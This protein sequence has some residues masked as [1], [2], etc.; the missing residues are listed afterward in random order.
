M[1][2]SNSSISIR[3]ELKES[4]GTLNILKVKQFPQI[5]NA[6]RY[7]EHLYQAAEDNACGQSLSMEY[8]HWYQY[9]HF[10]MHELP[11][12]REYQKKKEAVEKVLRPMTCDAMN[13]LEDVAR[14]MDLQQDE[15]NRLA[16]YSDF[17]DEFDCPPQSTPL[18]P[19]ASPLPDDISA[20]V[21]SST[22][23]AE[24]LSIL[25]TPVVELPPKTLTLHNFYPT[26]PRLDCSAKAS[27]HVE[28]ARQ[29][30][31]F[32]HEVVIKCSGFS[33]S[34]HMI[35]IVR[36]LGDVRRIM[37][38]NPYISLLHITIP[39]Y[40]PVIFAKDDYNVSFVPFLRNLPPDLLRVR[41]VV[42]TNRQGAF[43]LVVVI[44]YI[45][46]MLLPSRWC[47][48]VSTS[49]RITIVLSLRMQ[50]TFIDQ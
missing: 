17:I 21:R 30:Y 2:S 18:L 37:A 23:L 8:V 40:A 45:S 11:S 32:K 36:R 14:R 1:Q 38:P 24:K 39:G 34:I 41:D 9:I 33:F 7:A 35:E 12:H 29:L 16:E 19:A 47:G 48:N 15:V 13:K 4:H 44:N 27:E 43:N 49:L 20:H 5:E 6:V 31:S 25:S 22:R 28:E 42:E 10:V 26:A 50:F 46:Q 3:R